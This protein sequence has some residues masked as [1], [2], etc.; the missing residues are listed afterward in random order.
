MTFP[1]M[2]NERVEEIAERLAEA[3]NEQIGGQIVGHLHIFMQEEANG[4]SH[5]VTLHLIPLEYR[6][7][8]NFIRIIR[9]ISQWMTLELKKQ[10]G[11]L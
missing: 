2:S 3:V 6:T 8:E 1:E 7:G 4:Q 5:S 9:D 11:E 10:E